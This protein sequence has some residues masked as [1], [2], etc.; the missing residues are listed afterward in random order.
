[1]TRDILT[2]DKLPAGKAEGWQEFLPQKAEP[3]PEMEC[4]GCTE[5]GLA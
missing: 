2:P 1:M 4:E 5:Q 3:L